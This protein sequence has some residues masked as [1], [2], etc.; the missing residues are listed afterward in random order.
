MDNVD[1]GLWHNNLSGIANRSQSLAVVPSP[2]AMSVIPSTISFH[3]SSLFT[4][5]AATPAHC[6]PA[7][8]TDQ[9]V[10]YSDL[11]RER[12]HSSGSTSSIDTE[13][14]HFRPIRLAPVSDKQL[15]IARPA[16][17]RTST[18]TTCTLSTLRIG[19][20]VETDQDREEA[21]I[22]QEKMDCELA[23][24]IH[25]Q[26]KRFMLRQTS[27]R[28]QS[29]MLSRCKEMSDEKRRG[30]CRREGRKRQHTIEQCAVCLV[31]EL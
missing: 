9:T 14:T 12:S 20:E 6:R 7:H 24:R 17:V 15:V 28:K 27:T 16:P 30:T 13:F 22:K 21:R 19:V 23:W 18:V 26:E 5:P 3:P 2:T 29:P 1:N 31:T 8:Q 10:Q 25:K 4:K 11:A